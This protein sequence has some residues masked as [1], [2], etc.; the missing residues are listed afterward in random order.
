VVGGEHLPAGL[1]PDLGQDGLLDGDLSGEAL[2]AVADQR[3]GLPGGDQVDGGGQRG[4][5]L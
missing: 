2:E 1:L 3:L 5:V 4:P